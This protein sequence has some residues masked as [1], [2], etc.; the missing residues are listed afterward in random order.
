MDLASDTEIAEREATDAVVDGVYNQRTASNCMPVAGLIDGVIETCKRGIE[1]STNIDTGDTTNSGDIW[2]DMFGKTEPTEPGANGELNIDDDVVTDTLSAVDGD[3]DGGRL[4]VR[5]VQPACESTSKCESTADKE[6]VEATTAEDVEA[7]TAEDAEATTAESAE[8]TT[9]KDVEATTAK[10]AQESGVAH[11]APPAAI[12]DAKSDEEHLGAEDAEAVG[13]SDGSEHVLSSSVP[14]APD[15]A[16]PS[17]MDVDAKAPTAED[18]EAAVAL[19]PVVPQGVAPAEVTNK[20][21]PRGR[22]SKPMSFSNI[23]RAQVPRTQ[24]TATMAASV[25][26]TTAASTVIVGDDV[27]EMALKVQV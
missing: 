8:A 9:A 16:H 18:A 3:G 6:D 22:R 23:K 4:P 25:E 21:W 13:S 24:S 19:E 2:V 1:A 11:K 12:G 14:C 10:G 20:F 26:L 17:D 15:S 27:C 7:T 5:D